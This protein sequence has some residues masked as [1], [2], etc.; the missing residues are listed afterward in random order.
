MESGRSCGV[1]DG[2]DKG[3]S[4]G[5]AA[6]AAST[7]RIVHPNR[8]RR[9]LSGRLLAQR[10]AVLALVVRAVVAG[11]DRLPPGAVVAVP[12]DGALEALGEAHLRL[13]AERADLLGAERVAAVVAGA[14]GDV[15]DQ[16]LV[17][18]R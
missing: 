12:G 9:N 13:P 17:G 7:R 8:T 3:P 6:A 11:A 15:L 14:V 5:V 18:A 2:V 16:R 10:A 4:S 1:N